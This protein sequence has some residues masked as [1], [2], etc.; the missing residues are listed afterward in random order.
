VPSLHL[1]PIGSPRH[2]ADISTFVGRNTAI[3]ECY[4]N[5]DARDSWW[6]SV[7]DLNGL[8][9]G[10]V[11]ERSR[12]RVLPGTSLLRISRFGRDLH[13]P[14]IEQLPIIIPKVL[15]SFSFVQR[16]DVAVF[17]EDP[18]RRIKFEAGLAEAGLKRVPARSY[19]RTLWL[20]L[21]G[22]E[23]SLFARM[24]TSTRRNIREAE[25]AGIRA[26]PLTSANLVPA[27]TRLYEATFSRTG[28]DAPALDLTKVV[29]SAREQVSGLFGVFLR[30]EEGNPE[31]LVAFAWVR[32]NGDH[33]VYDVAAS[34]RRP[35]LGRTPLGYP[36]LWTCLKWARERGLRWMDLG[37]IP[38]STIPQTSPL[39]SIA[40]FKKGFCS[41][42]VEVGGEYRIEPSVLLSS[43]ARVVRG[44][45][46]NL[47]TTR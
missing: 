21:C 14:I 25:K 15:A 2:R 23:A 38:G 45:A 46:G 34:G 9:T 17:D 22:D 32:S 43:L 18:S 5:P 8:V 26:V 35:D 44:L 41:N 4:V 31:A 6:C 10:F 1:S 29:A 30:G 7:G 19:T 20:D 27:M 28:A 16:L 37:G 40:A 24:S 33:A 39:Q 47:G 42:E 12:S 11:V 3:P 36:L 13:T